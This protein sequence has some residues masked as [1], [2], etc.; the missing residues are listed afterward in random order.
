[1]FDYVGVQI[2][3][4]QGVFIHKRSVHSINMGMCTMREVCKSCVCLFYSVEFRELL[5]WIA[6]DCTGGRNIVANVT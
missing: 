2:C 5:Y 6:L 4:C 1:M 3:V